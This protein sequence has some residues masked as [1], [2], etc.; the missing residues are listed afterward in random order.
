MSGADL[1]SAQVNYLRTFHDP[2]ISERARQLFGPVPVQRPEAV[3]L[4]QPALGLKGAAAR[5]R[6]IFF[7]RCV[8]CHQRGGAAP[9]IGP[10]LA[11]AAVYGREEV[12]TAILEPNAGA[13]CDY[14]TYVVETAD[15]ESLI[16]LLRD[17]NPATITASSV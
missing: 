13:R 4:F 11:T 17:Q 6:E 14:L 3:K 12:L 15:G 8:V 9:A 7:A 16:G 5:G 1:S 2:A 10:D